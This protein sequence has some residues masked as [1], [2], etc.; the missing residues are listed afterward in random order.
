[1][2]EQ[3]AYQD[4]KDGT[5]TDL[6]TGLIWQKTPDFGTLRDFNAATAYANALVLGGKSEWRLPTVKELYSL[7][8]LPKSVW[9]DSDVESLSFWL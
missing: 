5:I 2:G 4:N 3:G 6:N 7:M 9:V 8:G 1:M